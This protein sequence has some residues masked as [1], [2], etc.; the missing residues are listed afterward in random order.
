M[1]KA[2]IVDG[3]RTPFLKAGTI[4][5]LSASEMA[6]TP[7]GEL[8]KRYPKLKE[9]CDCVVGANIGNQVLHPDGSNLAR[10]ILLKAGLDPRIPAWTVNINCGSGLHAVLDAVKNVELGLYKCILVVASEVMSDYVAV[11]NRQQRAQFAKLYEVS[12][13]KAPMWRRLPSLM[14]EWTKMKMMPHKPEWSI[15]IGLTDPV[16]KLGMDEIADQIAEEYKISREE[17]DLFALESQRRAKAA[18][19]SGRLKHE[20]VPFRGIDQDNGIRFDQNLSALSKLRP[21]H[22]GGT[23]TPGNSSQI[24]DGAVAL[25]VV[26]EELAKKNGWP[27]LATMYSRFSSIGGC[28]P[29]RMG[30]G[31]VQAIKQIFSHDWSTLD[32]IDVIETNEAFAAV[33]L[34]QQ[35]E[36]ELVKDNFG[37]LSPEKVNRNGGAIALGHPISA[38]GA[39]LVLTCAKELELTGAT[40]GLVTLCVGGGQ[41][42]AACLERGE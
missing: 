40:S 21:L 24:T 2:V 26:N 15:K 29:E 14:K 36:F 34:A 37:R 32:D 12:R 7:V 3:V 20:I 41:G 38:S 17:Q 16:C 10:V 13:K 11:Y 30:L 31:P 6:L 22:K 1:N 5:D 18:T 8:F 35:K 23:V 27:L 9:S 33:V 39:R 19:L 28:V 25:M 42:V 4:P